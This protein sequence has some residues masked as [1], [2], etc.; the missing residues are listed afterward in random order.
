MGFL[1]NLHEDVYVYLIP[2]QHYIACVVI[3]WCIK[4][5]PSNKTV[6][7]IRH[8]SAIKT[9]LV[10]RLKHWTKGFFYTSQVCLCVSVLHW[11]RGCQMKVQCSVLSRC[12]CSDATGRRIV[13]VCLFWCDWRANYRCVLVLMRLEGELS[14]YA[15]P[16]VIAH[17]K[18]SLRDCFPKQH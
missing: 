18:L 13:V 5:L 3:A 16:C 15:C 6:V 12:A 11:S 2:V 7:H 14:R 4:W 10:T 8:F 9:R 1:Q 17:P